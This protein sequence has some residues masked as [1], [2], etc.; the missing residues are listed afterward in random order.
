MR[1]LQAGMDDYLAKPVRAAELF[2]A[3]EQVVGKRSAT[4]LVR[5]DA[6]LPSELLDPEALL[7]ACDGDAD[8]LRKMCRHFEA[9]VPGL[10]AEVGVALQERDSTRL[11]EA[12]HKLGGIVS[13]FSAKAAEATD[14]LGR[15][16]GDR[17]FEE[18]I[19]THARL[20]EMLQKIV[21]CLGTLSISQLRRR[22]DVVR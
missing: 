8:L 20:A 11:R 18:A 13:S 17:D 5:A 3:L 9:H 1:C 19:N 4:G 12:L 7:A 21:S 10:L 6:D 14:L 22:K 16:S 15:L 2:T